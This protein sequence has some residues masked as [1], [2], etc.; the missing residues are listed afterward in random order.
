MP[1]PILLEEHYLQLM[2]NDAGMQHAHKALQDKKKC[3]VGEIKKRYAS[4]SLVNFNIIIPETLTVAKGG[5]MLPYVGYWGDI[6]GI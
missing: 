2:Q 3:I 1:S 5:V 4:Y 6:G